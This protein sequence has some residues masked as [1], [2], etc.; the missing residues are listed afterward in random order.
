MVL[1]LTRVCATPPLPSAPPPPATLYRVVSTFA[2]G[3]EVADY[4][5]AATASM[6]ATLAREVGVSVSAVSLSLAAGS[7]LVTSEIHLATEAAATEAARSLA[8]GMRAWLDQQR[9]RPYPLLTVTLPPGTQKSESL[10][11]GRMFFSLFCLSL[12]CNHQPN[13]PRTKKNSSLDFEG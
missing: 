3:G 5:D 1:S 12:I 4:S 8:E 6:R 13:S 11:R 7:V 2:L 10:R 9:Q